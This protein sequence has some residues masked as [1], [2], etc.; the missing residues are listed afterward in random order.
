M[1]KTIISLF[2]A[3]AIF[4]PT[5]LWGGPVIQNFMYNDSVATRMQS[6]AGDYF[7]I[8]T[9]C[10]TDHSLDSEND[11]IVCG[12]IEINGKSFF[13]D[14][15]T[16]TFSLDADNDIGLT[17][18][19]TSTGDF[20]NVAAI[21]TSITSGGMLSVDDI[22]YGHKI[23][24]NTNASDVADSLIAGVLVANMN[25]SGSPGTIAGFG[26][27]MDGSFGS[28]VPTNTESVLGMSIGVR[29]DVGA[30]SVQ[31]ISVKVQSESV[32][33]VELVSLN[34]EVEPN[35][36][37][38]R[39]I[40]I[41]ILNVGSQI[42]DAAIHLEGNF[43]S[44]IFFNS[45]TYVDGIDFST[46]TYTNAIDLSDATVTTDINL[47]S[48]VIN[49]TSG[50]ITL[51]TTTSGDILLTSI[52]QVEITV[53]DNTSS[54]YI[55]KD[56]AA[57]TIF[58][59]TT[60]NGSEGIVLGN[61]NGFNTS[62]FLKDNS[63]DALDVQEFA[64]NYI[65]IDTSDG[66]EIITLS[67]L[68][69]VHLLPATDLVLSDGNKSGSTYA[70]E[71]ILSDAF[72]EWD[73]F[74]TNFGEVSLFNALNQVA[75]MGG[76]TLDDAYDFGGAGVGRAIIADTGAVTITVPIGSNNAG[77][78]LI[79]NNTTHSPNGLLVTNAAN[80]NG[81]FIDSNG[82]GTS[83]M[84][85]SEGTAAI[86][87]NI[88]TP[89][90]S[91]GSVFGT[92]ANSLTSGKIFNFTSSSTS[93]TV[94]TLGQIT[95]DN[96]SAINATVLTLQQDA[97]ERNLFVDT[98]ADTTS[99]FVDSES[100]SN[101]VLSFS[102]PAT[103]TGNV[104]LVSSANSLTTG[105]MLRLESNSASTN[106]RN[107]GFILNDN[108]SAF[109]TTVLA[110]QQDADVAN[111][112]LD[113]NGNGPSITIA[114]SATSA[115][116][117]NIPIPATTGGNVF[118]STANSLTTGK[119]FNFT[120]SSANTS[121]RTL[122]LITNDNAAAIGAIVLT[123]QQDAANENL[124]IDTNGDGDSILIDTEATIANGISFLNPQQTTGYLFDVDTADQLTT[125]RITSFISDSADTGTRTLGFYHNDNTLATGAAVLSLQQ[126]STAN[127]LFVDK[128]DAG[129]GIEVDLD[130]NSASDAIGLLINVTNA[131]AG[132][133]IGLVI[134]T[135]NVGIGTIT[136][137]ASLELNGTLALTPSSTQVLVA[138]TALTVTNTIMRID[139]GAAG[140]I[141]MTA[142]PTIVDAVGDGTCVI[143]QGDDDVNTITFQDEGNL[144]NSGLQLSGGIDFTFGQGDT[145]HLCYDL[146]MDDWLEI[147]RS[148]N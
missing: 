32:A 9:A 78:E 57:E 142:T 50:D 144:A 61:S 38:L 73:T 93:T 141:T 87:V 8:G 117:V 127:G 138:G 19:A 1:K 4:V 121:V 120:S 45:G 30:N 21:H 40:G 107:L 94:R 71:F 147:S 91:T 145:L 56:S 33:A 48:G 42:A 17:I 77:L 83:L 55:I 58:S 99:I 105:S 143:V 109:N 65:H 80:G 59:A 53:A 108:S 62:I 103:T 26:V 114:S 60:T 112:F 76:V 51:Q 89:T 85:D 139:S 54:A 82:F 15:M 135:G 31:G 100:T 27:A 41:R 140:A 131:G 111:L 104:I 133:D 5:F 113:S 132:D 46:S 12:E 88:P 44:G 128:N 98:N 35:V 43:D 79:Q 34:V 2:A 96:A 6:P 23:E 110:L 28:I 64:A 84:I 72:G 122:G 47:G 119:I 22:T 69:D 130:A 129:N 75:G 14:F 97:T 102:A 16:A 74:E 49:H 95:N 63:A 7:S 124:F 118:S 67:G 90:T 66:S 37:G 137:S 146:G 123:L 10:T 36:A 134:Q 136:P 24:F 20:T 18:N 81:I 125:G 115:S 52:D 126:D 25:A 86:V 68:G 11:I 106:V 29:S 70:T 3:L 116:V 101:P 39:D 148:D 13:D 92:T